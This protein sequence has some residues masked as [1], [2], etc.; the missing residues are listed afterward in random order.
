MIYTF[1]FVLFEITLVALPIGAAR[2]KGYFID[3]K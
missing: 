3:L 1:D 2:M